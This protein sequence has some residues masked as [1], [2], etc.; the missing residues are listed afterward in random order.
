M[1]MP[2]Q[3]G[4]QTPGQPTCNVMIEGNPIGHPC[5]LQPQHAGPHA[6]AAMPQSI[7][8]R[9]RW[10]ASVEAPQAAPAAPAPAAAPMAPMAPAPTPPGQVVNASVPTRTPMPPMPGVS[11]TPVAAP[12]PSAPAA[13]TYAAGVP[14]VTEGRTF[15]QANTPPADP[16]VQPATVQ[17]S[18]GVLPQP[19]HLAP[20]APEPTVPTNAPVAPAPVPPMTGVPT[21]LPDAG[22]TT[23]PPAEARAVAEAVATSSQPA[24]ILNAGV[25]IQDLVMADMA[26]RKAVGIERYGTVLQAF[27][28]R[29]ALTDMYEELL[30][31]AT[32]VRQLIEEEAQVGNYSQATFAEHIVSIVR[33]VSRAAQA[34]GQGVSA[35][36]IANEVAARTFPVLA[37]VW[38]DGEAKGAIAEAG[39]TFTLIR[40]YR[41][42]N[43]GM[44][45]SEAFTRCLSCKTE[46]SI[47]TNPWQE[48]EAAL[49][50]QVA[51]VAPTQGSTG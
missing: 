17:T 34:Q 23:T 30:D 15:V 46:H 20:T 38:R 51:Q 7:A 48:V 11:A 3:G 10:I 1:T 43:C 33:E 50:Q 12:P 13:E 49:R 41:C 45:I 29:S 16:T 25:A 35:E 24:P 9:Q 6:A 36:L 19:A 21:T 28:G 40:L 18:P 47:E 22:V 37:T 39:A 4:V 8:A 44:L 5:D 27:N 42:G 14:L 32:Y 31:G 2:S 26:H